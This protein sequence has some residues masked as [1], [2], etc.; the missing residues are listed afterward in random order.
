MNRKI[1]ILLFALLILS[2]SDKSD[3]ISL[4]PRVHK[5]RVFKTEITEEYPEISS[6]GSISFVNKAD[7]TAV[8][9]ANIE[10]IRVREGDFVRMN[11]LLV[12]LHNP[13]LDI[14]LSQAKVSVNSAESAVALSQAKYWE[15]Q[16]SVEARIISLEKEYMSLDQARIELQELE[17]NY[18]DKKAL[19]DVGGVAEKA[20]ESVKSDYD[21]ALA[22]YQIME[23]DIDIRALGL[24]DSD[25]QARGYAVPE[26]P[27]KKKELL[28]KLNTETL[29]AELEVA[30]S[31]L[32]S[33][34]SELQSTQLLMKDLMIY[35]PIEGII[36][37]RYLE[38]GER[39]SPGTKVMTIFNE[40]S[41]Y[42]VFPVQEK[43]IDSI[44]K[45]M[46]VRTIVDAF[47]EKEFT[48]IIDIISPIVDPQSGSFS[49]K[50]KITNPDNSL[51]PGMFVRTRIINDNPRNVVRIP[52]TCLTGKR[53]DNARIF[54]VKGDR[55]FI[56]TVATGTE[57]NGMVEI[58]SE[59]DEGELIVDSPSPVIA[60]GD[61]VEI[62]E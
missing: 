48:G 1:F 55:V 52:S 21:A 20:L 33:A 35:A 11:Q 58:I 18:E 8:L 9:D 51:K 50:A 27:E 19:Y 15:G 34:E 46:K 43:D 60:E 54:V 37:S 42:A 14:R 49:V 3:R 40:G 61:N 31:R 6:F 7:V 32:L 56:M 53:D 57:K 12:V 41:V 25:L 44:R 39:V 5:V 17:K 26:D 47:E 13:Q 30:K 59:I 36:G 28:V 29:A 22:S 45:G 62:I 16:L 4:Q 24:R 23:K 2:C 38:P 10:S